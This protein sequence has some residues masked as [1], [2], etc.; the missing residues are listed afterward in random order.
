MFNKKILLCMAVIVG[1]GFL[2]SRSVLSQAPEGS[3]K[4][5]I[6]E[7]L[8]PEDQKIL[9]TSDEISEIED[10]IVQEIRGKGAGNRFIVF[11]EGKSKHWEFLRTKDQEILQTSDG[12]QINIKAGGWV[13]LK[14]EENGIEFTFESASPHIPE[15]SFTIP[16]PAEPGPSLPDGPVR[17]GNYSINIWTQGRLHRYAGKI[18][19][20]GYAFVGEGDEKNRLTFVVLERSYVYVRGKGRVILPNGQEIKLGY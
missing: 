9:Q 1:F 18:N 13:N 19:C 20:A 4:S 3:N 15:T 8:G 6:W 11:E 16:F 5:E 17:L 14:A 12:V 2:I 10:R 7:S